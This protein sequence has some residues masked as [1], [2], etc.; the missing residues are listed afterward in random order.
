[1]R[2]AG[3]DDCYTPVMR[4]GT[5][6]LMMLLLAGCSMVGESPMGVLRTAEEIQSATVGPAAATSY[7]VRAYRRILSRPGSARDF[8]DVYRDATPAGKV[9]AMAGLYDT[10]RRTFD[11]LIQT[12][13]INPGATLSY[14]DGCL[15]R[16]MDRD[17][18]R[19]KLMTGHFSRLW[20]K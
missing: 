14:T 9:Y 8:A 11:R 4:V 6:L 18:V 3:R 15:V 1:M 13:F 10:D 17:E 7:Y 2:E 16:A 20:R 19:E 5:A 12:D